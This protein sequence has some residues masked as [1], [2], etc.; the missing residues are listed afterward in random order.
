MGGE[1]RC[2]MFVL[3]ATDIVL[4]ICGVFTDYLYK[5]ELSVMQHFIETL[6][7]LIGLVQ[8]T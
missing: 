3:E 5:V 4:L 1:W 7:L 8:G 6:Q 2:G